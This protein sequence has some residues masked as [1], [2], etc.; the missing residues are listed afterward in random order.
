MPA[1]EIQAA[2]GN[3]RIVALFEL[4]N[5]FVNASVLRRLND[6]TAPNGIIKQRQVLRNRT[7][8]L[9]NVLVN[10]GNRVDDNRTRQFAPL[11]AVETNFAAPFFVKTRD[12][13]GDG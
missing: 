3:F 6:I 2:F 1:A 11:H 5:I 10:G 8:D 7:G 4:Q 13:F 12:D 9:E